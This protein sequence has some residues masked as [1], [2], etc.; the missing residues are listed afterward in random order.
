MSLCA[1]EM[2]YVSIIDSS[3]HTSHP[4]LGRLFTCF[5]KL[6]YYLVSCFLITNV[7]MC[8]YNITI[9]SLIPAH[10]LG[11]LAA[12]CHIGL[13]QYA[14]LLQ[15]TTPCEDH[16]PQDPQAFGIS[17]QL[18]FSKCVFGNIAKER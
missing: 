13:S 16:F 14:T 12:Y 4:M 9:E 18:L 8:S 11:G 7:L 15:C 3:Q 5:L 1:M 2:G 6:W 10:V 17:E